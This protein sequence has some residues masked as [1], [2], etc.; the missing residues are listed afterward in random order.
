MG[1]CLFVF[2]R[3]SSSDNDDEP[4]ELAECDVGHYSDFGYFR[5]TIARHLGGSQFPTLMNH[6]DCDGQW[7]ISE[8]SALKNELLEI[9]KRFGSL[10]AE[11]PINAFEHTADYRA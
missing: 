7:K 1:L 3:D 9:A 5:D 4:E 11:E 8:L 10:P 2:D 6:S